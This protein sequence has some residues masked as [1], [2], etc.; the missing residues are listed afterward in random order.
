MGFEI[1][2]NSVQVPLFAKGG[3]SAAGGGETVRGDC[4]SQGPSR[5]C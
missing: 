4:H 2:E 3:G 5:S 1:L